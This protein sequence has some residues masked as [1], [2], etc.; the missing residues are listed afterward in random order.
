MSIYFSS[1]D[2]RNYDHL[3]CDWSTTSFFSNSAKRHTQFLSDTAS[4]DLTGSIWQQ[5][6]HNQNTDS[7]FVFDNSHWSGHLPPSIPYRFVYYMYSQKWVK[8]YVMCIYTYI[9][10]IHIS[11]TIIYIYVQLRDLE[12]SYGFFASEAWRIVNPPKN[13]GGLTHLPACLKSQAKDLYL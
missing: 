4:S 6:S 2:V 1:C 9:L 3:T 13:L 5:F 11:Y 8:F 7:W 10:Y 12:G